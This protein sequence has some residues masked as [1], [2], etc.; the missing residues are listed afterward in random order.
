MITTKGFRDS[1]EMRRGIKPVDVSLYNSI[2]STQSA[3]DPALAPHRR[4]RAHAVRRQHH[5]ATQRAGSGEAAK[6]FKA[7]GVKSIAVC[8]LHSYANPKHERRAAEICREVAPDIFVSTSHET[9]PVWREFE[10]FNTTAVGSYVGPAVA[11]YLTSLE[12]VLK[13]SGFRGTFPDDAGQRPGAEH[14]RMH[15][16]T[17]ISTAFRSG[18]CAV[19]SSLSWTSIL[20]R[21]KSTLGRYGWNKLR[22]M[23]DRQG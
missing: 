9:L 14:R 7:Q 22:R 13:D 4:R 1:I 8:F 10:R 2:H 16:P 19:R 17:G 21:E 23:R 18:G 3:T 6:K 5:D 12:T 11:R 15:S 20:A